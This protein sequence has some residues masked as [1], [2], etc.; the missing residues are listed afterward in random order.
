MNVAAEKTCESDT[1]EPGEERRKCKYCNGKARKFHE[2]CPKCGAKLKLV[3]I[4]REMG[5]EYRRRKP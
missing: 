2:T 5:E 1:F 3:R 4:I